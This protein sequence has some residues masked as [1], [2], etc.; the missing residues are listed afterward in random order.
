MIYHWAIFHRRALAERA[1]PHGTLLRQQPRGAHR[2]VEQVTRAQP[3]AVYCFK[4][5]ENIS[6]DMKTHSK[7]SHTNTARTIVWFLCQTQVKHC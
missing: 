4:V 5:S 1:S 2:H 3:K 6:P 7:R